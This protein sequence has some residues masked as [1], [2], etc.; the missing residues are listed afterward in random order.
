MSKGTN[1]MTKSPR[2]IQ[3]T[4]KEAEACTAKMPWERGLRRQA[5]IASRRAVAQLA[6]M[7]NRTARPAA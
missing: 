4:L 1:P 5:F 6:A 7:P 2:W 3:S